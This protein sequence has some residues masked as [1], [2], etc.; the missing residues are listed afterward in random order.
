MLSSN[1][2]WLCR[3]EWEE[4]IAKIDGD[5]GTGRGDCNVLMSMQWNSGESG[6]MHFAR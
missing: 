4:E 5:F 1:H 3:V 2:A 6:K